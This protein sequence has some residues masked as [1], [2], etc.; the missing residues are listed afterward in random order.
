MTPIALSWVSQMMLL[1]P[2]A[3]APC[4]AEEFDGVCTLPLQEASGPFQLNLEKQ[5]PL[6]ER[7]TSSGNLPSPASPC[8]G[9]PQG[10]AEEASRDCVPLGGQGHGFRRDAG[11]GAMASRFL[12]ISFGLKS[13]FD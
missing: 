1:Q 11:L 13:A 3:R 2:Q 9:V 4:Q 12:V 7:G 6:A 8:S 10:E 5:L